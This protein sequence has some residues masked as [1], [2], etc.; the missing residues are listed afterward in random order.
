MKKLLALVLVAFASLIAL[1]AIP[2]SVHAQGGPGLVCV[3]TTGSATCPS[4]IPTFTGAQGSTV[5]V[6]VLLQGS[7]PLSSFDV[8]V[9][10]INTI[11]L[12]QSA[13]LTGSLITTPSGT[14]ICL[15]GAAAVGSCTNPANGPGVVEVSTADGS[16]NNVCSSCSGLLFTITYSISGSGATDLTY[17]SN[18]NCTPSSVGTSSTCIL[19][20]DNLGNVESEN[21]QTGTFSNAA[22][23][24]SAL[25][26]TNTLSILQSLSGTSSIVVSS[27]GGFGGSVS[28]SAAVTPLV[29]NGPTASVSPTSVSV[30]PGGT[31]TAT[32]TV[33]TTS[34]TPTGSYTVTVTATGGSISHD[35]PV[36]VSVVPFTGVAFIKAGLKWTHNLRVASSGGVQTW[37]AFLNNTAGVGEAI[38]IQISG[39]SSSGSYSHSFSTSLSFSGSGSVTFTTPVPAV[40]QGSRITFTAIL[41]F[42]PSPQTQS[43]TSISGSFKA[44]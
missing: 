39:T 13:D 34:L 33:L 11:L 2:L 43:P 8:F 12:P 10:T 16:G 14:D 18:P 25:A 17:P 6:A 23:D 20:L 24:F 27:T 29:T 36:T 19:I 42:G 15:N 28:L 3:A 7:G 31:N 41:F 22:P 30:S 32:L 26:N 9:S 40:F 35:A 1:P 38:T 21:A 37:T 44:V 4:T 5:T